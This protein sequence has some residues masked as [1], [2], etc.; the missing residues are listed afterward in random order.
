LL[1]I[2]RLKE[3]TPRLDKEGSAGDRLVLVTVI[4]TAPKERGTTNVEV[5]GDRGH[6]YIH[7]V[8]IT[9]FRKVG[10]SEE[11]DFDQ[12]QALAQKPGPR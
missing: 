4:E 7:H 10:G 1:P 2:A 8:I 3:S 6:G 12:C 5:E 9:F 11:I